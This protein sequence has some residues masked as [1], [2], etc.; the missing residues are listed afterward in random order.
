MKILRRY[1][2]RSLK[3]DSKKLRPLLKDAVN[4]IR[5]LVKNKIYMFFKF[6]FNNFERSIKYCCICAVE[7][8]YKGSPLIFISN[9]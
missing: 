5:R 7:E 8:A 9:N 1:I 4:T 3:C 6:K 2:Y